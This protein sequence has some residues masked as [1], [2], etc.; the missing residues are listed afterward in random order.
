MSY[1]HLWSICLFFVKLYVKTNPQIII[2]LTR[3]FYSFKQNLY[4]SNLEI[5]EV[6]FLPV[7]LISTCWL[8]YCCNSCHPPWRSWLAPFTP[9]WIPVLC[10]SYTDPLLLASLLS[11]FSQPGSVHWSLSRFMATSSSWNALLSVIS[12]LL[13][14]QGSAQPSF[15]LHSREWTKLGKL[16]SSS[17]CIC[18][19][20]SNGHALCSPSCHLCFSSILSQAAFLLPASSYAFSFLCSKVLTRYQRNVSLPLSYLLSLLYSFHMQ[21][22]K[23]L[24]MAS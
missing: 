1:S 21:M 17:C 5:W 8:K 16:C 6:L 12:D 4:Q 7:P 24:I 2:Y 11:S 13:F 15:L 19:V 22:T 9:V 23:F 18:H 10:R 14:L 20:S 3:W